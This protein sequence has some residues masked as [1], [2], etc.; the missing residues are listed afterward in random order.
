MKRGR[1]V[2]KTRLTSKSTLKRSQPLRKHWAP[3]KKRPDPLELAEKRRRAQVRRRVYERDGHCLLSMLPKAAG[4]CF[5]PRTP[6]HLQKSQMGGN[7]AL[8]TEDNLVWL[9]AHH[10]DWVEQYPLVARQVGLVVCLTITPD[11]AAERR[12]LYGLVP[13][14]T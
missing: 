5:G 4:S 7:P 3:A 13:R 14:G 2:R 9:C 8:Y 1:L 6:H 12:E 11:M 10:N